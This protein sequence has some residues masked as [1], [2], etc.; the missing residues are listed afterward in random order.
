MQAI[1]TYTTRTP[2]V[3]RTGLVASVQDGLKK[4]QRRTA[5]MDPDGWPI[6]LLYGFGVYTAWIL[7][8]GAILLVFGQI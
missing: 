3:P 2:V 5:S 8:S 7:V 1:S 6:A 4:V